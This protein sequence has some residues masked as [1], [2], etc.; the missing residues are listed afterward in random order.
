MDADPS[1]GSV[2]C[3]SKQNSKTAWTSLP[4]QLSSQEDPTG[5][6][7][8]PSSFYFVLYRW[9]LILLMDPLSAPK[10]NQK[11]LDP[12]GSMSDP[13]GLKSCNC[14][15]VN[16]VLQF[17]WITRILLKDPRVLC[18]FAELC[19]SFPARLQELAKVTKGERLRH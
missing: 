8:D 5:I 2:F 7:M 19:R 14:R 15:N 17:L 13:L 1:H 3:A 12:C 18:E 11:S 9:T 4:F 16:A 6:H 10:P